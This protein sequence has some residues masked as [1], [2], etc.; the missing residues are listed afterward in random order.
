MEDIY[1]LRFIR[2]FQTI[3]LDSALVV[4]CIIGNARVAQFKEVV[5]D[6]SWIKWQVARGMAALLVELMS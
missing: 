3:C 4:V 5:V 2:W 1:G 6:W